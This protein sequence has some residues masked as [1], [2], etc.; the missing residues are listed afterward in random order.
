MM[1]SIL[2]VST[3]YLRTFRALLNVLN[4]LAVEHLEQLSP[5]I[6]VLTTLGIDQVEHSV[7]TTVRCTPRTVLP[8]G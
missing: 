5:V 1:V 7:R 3:R 6:N 2:L 8:A 4:G